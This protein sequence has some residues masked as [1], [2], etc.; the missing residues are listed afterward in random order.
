MADYP[1]ALDK[2]SKKYTCPEC[3]HKSFVAYLKNG[4]NE[5]VDIDQFG[6]CDR[7]N[8]CGYHKHPGKS[9]ESHLNNKPALNPDHIKVEQIFPAKEKIDEYLLAPRN[10]VGNFYRYCK[11][12]SIPSDHLLKWLVVEYQDKTVFLYKDKNNRLSNIKWFKYNEKGHRV[13][14]FNPYSL[15]QPKQTA[16]Q[17]NTTISKYFLCLFG[18]H[19]L[20]P[21]K[22]KTVCVVESE[23][24]AVLASFFYPQFDW[25]ACGSSSGLSD[26]TNATADKITPLFNRKVYWLCDADKA[27]RLNSS[28]R[29]LVKY[30]IDH[31]VIDLFPDR[32]DG[33]DLADAI[34]DDLRPD[35]TPAPKV[36]KE[37][38]QDYQA[39]MY[40]LP[41]NVEWENVKLDILKYGHFVHN[42]KIFMIRKPKKEGDG[43]SCT[44]ITN[45]TINPLGLIT[46]KF[47]PRRLIEIKNIFNIKKVLEVPTKAFASQTEFTVFIES[48]GNFQYD[49]IGIDLKK[50][51][52]KLYDNMSSFEEVESLGW[53]KEGYFIFANGVF[54]GQF[55]PI[56]DFGFVRMGK[57]NFYIEPLSGINRDQDGE[58]E[59]EKKLI[60]TE[61][62]DITIKDWAHLFCDVHGDNGKIALA[63]YISSLFRDHIFR[64]FKFFPHWFGFGPPGTGKSQV[65]WSIRSTFFSGIKK[66]FTLSLGTSVAFSKEVSQFSN[67][68]CWY[69]EYENSIDPARINGLKGFYDGSGHTKSVKE[70][71]KRT[72]S[73]PVLAACMITGQQLPIA[74]I[75]LFTRVILCQFHKAEFNNEERS[76]YNKLEKLQESGMPEISMFFFKHRSLIENSYYDTYDDIANEFHQEFQN[77]EV[78]TRLV[79]NMSVLL[80]TLKILEK[81]LKDIIPFTYEYFWQ[82]AVENVKSQASLISNANET[83]NFWDMMSFLIDQG[84]IEKGKDFDF[85]KR[86]EIKLRSLTSEPLVVRFGTLKEL[87]FLRFSRI[88]PLYQEHFNKQNR[89]SQPL[90]KGS[91]LH[92]LQ[93]T[94]EYVG[95][96][97]NYRF[98]SAPTTAFVFDNEILLNKDIELKRGYQNK[99]LGL[100]ENGVGSSSVTNQDEIRF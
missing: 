45:F 23:K 77:I 3:H 26:G 73:V 67:I 12:L 34:M 63:W 57:K 99:D 24:S 49:G 91:L 9:A 52:A 46:S 60:Y 29:N 20:D 89:N 47:A 42:G 17:E 54:N 58:W 14:G 48:E 70:S 2:S 6:R 50:V 94:K 40:N 72:E 4:S 43:Y 85:D 31:E 7:E 35:I 33:Y 79:R 66:P 64:R 76:L 21:K 55:K 56:D 92:Y 1:F 61:R 59:D 15:K 96:F 10:D 18:E 81:E 84:L 41:K 65:G 80:T 39:Y 25:V 90:D 53:H 86:S 87:L 83:N 28:I 22:K 62:K 32:N 69:D 100:P 13:K 68:P 19:L 8:N 44:H 75:A 38:E 37:N 30:N 82:L 74:D 51:R 88:V 95:S 98:D 16:G 11:K 93:H 71:K 5:L 27:G 36:E 97:K 78:H